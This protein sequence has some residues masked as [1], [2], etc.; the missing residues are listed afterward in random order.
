VIK[1]TTIEETVHVQG[2]S[3]IQ[4]TLTRSI[5]TGDV[6]LDSVD[7]NGDSATCE[8]VKHFNSFDL[9]NATGSFNL[10][11]GMYN[12]VL[13]VNCVT[14]ADDSTLADFDQYFAKDFGLILTAGKLS[15]LGDI[16]L[17]PEF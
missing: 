6:Y 12:D 17:I 16:Y 14:I 9:A 13:Q 15:V 4:R 2:A 3:N 7:E 1:D 5:N 10:A 11:A 8:V